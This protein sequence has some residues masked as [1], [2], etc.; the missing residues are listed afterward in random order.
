MPPIQVYNA[1]TYDPAPRRSSAPY[2]AS[3]FTYPGYRE[4]APNWTASRR[5]PF[6]EFSYNYKEG[7]YPGNDPT[8]IPDFYVGPRK[9]QP[10]Y[11]FR[12][13]NSPLNPR[14]PGYYPGPQTSR[15]VAGAGQGEEMGRIEWPQAGPEVTTEQRLQ[16]AQTQIAQM[17]DVENQLRAQLE[18]ARQQPE[19]ERGRQPHPGP[20]AD[21]YSVPRPPGWTGPPGTGPAGIYKECAAMMGVKS[22][23]MKTPRPFSG[24][25]ADIEQF[26][27]DCT[28]YFEAF[29]AYYLEMPSL[30][31]TFATSHL[32]GEAESW[33][34]HL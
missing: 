24:T 13:P 30:M 31:I 6:E 3:S 33:W 10:E 15:L 29:Q 19:P 32:E 26:L 12:L 9:G 14:C 17:C 11:N 7:F 34:V 28:M 23:L 16:Q 8:D 4:T 20:Q 2:N 25:H 1:P 27:G 22:I 18:E 21:M 5:N